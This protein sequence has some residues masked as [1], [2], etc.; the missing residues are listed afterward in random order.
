MYY[1]L[2]RAVKMKAVSKVFVPYLACLLMYFRNIHSTGFFI[3]IERKTIP[4]ST[5]SFQ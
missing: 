3:S 1:F 4:S 5:A 2:E